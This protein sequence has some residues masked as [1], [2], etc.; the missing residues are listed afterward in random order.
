MS[1]KWM[2]RADATRSART[3][4]EQ[5][6]PERDLQSTEFFLIVRTLP[7]AVA[8]P[9][10]YDNTLHHC[11]AKCLQRSPCCKCLASHRGETT[12]PD[13]EPHISSAGHPLTARSGAMP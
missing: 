7:R 13:A 4:G 5:Q 8:V 3:L 1:P 9:G 2:M 11:V 12:R 6:R 10:N